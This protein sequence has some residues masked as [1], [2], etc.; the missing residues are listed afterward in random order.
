MADLSDRSAERAQLLIIA[1]VGLAI[2]LV[3]MA[4]ALNTAVYGGV[5]VASTDDSLQEERAAL[6]YQDAV[7]R[8][9]VELL[10]E[11]TETGDYGELETALDSEV[12]NVTDLVNRQFMDDGIATRTAVSEPL[13]E[14]SV[15]HDNETRNFT[16]RGHQDTTW[17]VAEDVSNVSRFEMDVNDDE[18][19]HVGDCQSSEECFNITVNDGAW[20]MAIWEQSGNTT[21]EY[22]YSGGGDKY[23]CDVPTATI[24]FVEGKSED[25]EENNFVS[26]TE[27]L[28]PPYKIEYSDTGNVTGTYSLTVDGKLDEDNFHGNETDKSP[29]IGAEL[30]GVEVTVEYRTANLHYRN[31][32]RLMRGE[33]YG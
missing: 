18:L 7:E 3:L 2:L 27:V 6:E 29:R 13:F 11:V 20:H 21:I 28:D 32:I 22:E 19:S 26:F 9:L 17:V 12:A 10:P 25:C 14:T 31:E 30:V 1:G 8:G 15:I 24:D 23:D 16:N 5:H 4:L 33:D